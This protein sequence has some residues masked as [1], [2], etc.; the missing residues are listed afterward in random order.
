LRRPVHGQKRNAGPLPLQHR[1]RAIV[2]RGYGT[3]GAII[4][5]TQAAMQSSMIAA[6]DAPHPPIIK[7]VLECN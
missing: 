3:H 2:R 1:G 6:A 4:L 7:G 5:S